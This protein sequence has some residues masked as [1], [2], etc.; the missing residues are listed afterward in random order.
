[1]FHVCE[2]G[3]ATLC[4]VVGCFRGEKPPLREVRPRE[5]SQ[6][7]LRRPLAKPRSSPAPQLAI[8]AVA[9]PVFHFSLPP[10]PHE[11]QPGHDFAQKFDR[12]IPVAAA[13]VA[14]RG[15]AS[16]PKRFQRRY[17]AS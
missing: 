16:P 11:H 17:V 8:E 1:M 13:R 15:C 5:Q 3:H 10:K 2:A 9:N 6:H 4:G 14:L 12:C 7:A